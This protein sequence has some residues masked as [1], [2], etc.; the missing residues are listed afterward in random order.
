M[1]KLTFTFICFVFVTITNAQNSQNVWDSIKSSAL[2][3]VLPAFVNQYNSPYRQPLADYGWEDGLQISPD[4]LNLYA[5]YSPMDFISW[6]SFLVSNLSLPICS[7]ISNMS[8]IRPYANTY[9]IDLVTNPFGCDSFPNTDII[10]S[11]RNT[12]NDSFSTWQLSGIP[13]AGSIEGGPATLFSEVDSS[14]LDLF[15][16]TDNGD[17]WMIRNTT[18][19]PTGINN[20]VRLP[21]PINPDSNEFNADNAFLERINGDSIILIYEKY[22]NPGIRE[23]MYVLSDDIGNTWS[24]PQTIT[25]INN[26]LGHIEHPSLYKDNSS[27]EWWLYFS[28]DYTYIARARQSIAGN[29]DS[30]DSPENIIHKGNGLSL[31]EPTVT[32][33][34]DI[35][36]SLAYINNVINDSTD[37]YDLDPWILPRITAT[38]I[39]NNIVNDDQIKLKIQPNPFSYK[40]TLHTDKILK[41]A[42]LI[43]YNVFGQQVKQIKNISGQTIF[44]EREDL[45]SG[46]YFIRM[47]EEDISIVVDKLF[48]VDK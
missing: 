10:Y 38:G 26:S 39:D 23:F 6:Q 30:W 41:D 20:A 29:W 44:F 43:V 48:I 9:G 36:F 37:V 22:T 27:N 28:I 35:S 47:L 16:F 31:G 33:N 24:V 34:G 13:R 25:T 15:C 21:S 19:N 1:K 42:T 18:A 40:T 2:P 11:H 3:I 4:G 32:K 12:V 14:Q 7:T 5:L 46:L 8:F 17:I 45:S